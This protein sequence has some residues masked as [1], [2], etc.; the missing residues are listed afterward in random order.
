V[1]L[2]EHDACPLEP[3]EGGWRLA[4]TAVYRLGDGPARLDYLVACEDL[5]GLH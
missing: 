4:G 1:E 2:V 5:T 3:A